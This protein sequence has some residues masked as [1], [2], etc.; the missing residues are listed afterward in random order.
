MGHQF[1]QG[2]LA[3]L[4]DRIPMGRLAT[5]DDIAGA[6]AYLA[7]DDAAFVTGEMLDVNGGLF[8]AT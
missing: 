5:P 4:R 6:V 3:T 7:S 2:Q 1:T 8:L